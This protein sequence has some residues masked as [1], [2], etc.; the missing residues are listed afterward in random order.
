M[1][2]ALLIIP[3]LI[4]LLAGLCLP[5]FRFKERKHRE[6][7]V[8]VPVLIT[9]IIVY[10]LIFNRPEGTLTLIHLTKNLS[11]SLRLDGLSCVFAALV[12]GLWPLASCYAFEYIKHE[13]GDDRFFAFYTMTYGITLGIAFSAN[14]I[15]LYLFY[16]LLT[17]ITLP[18]VMHSMDNRSVKAGIK[19][20]A[21][22]IGG[23]ACAF[24]GMMVLYFY[25]NPELT[26]T[27]GGFMTLTDSNR[28]IV[29]IAYLLTFFGF[30]VK[31]AV[32]PFHGW[33]PSAGVAPTPVTALLHAVAVVKAGVFAIMRV[34][35]F[36][37]GVSVLRGTYAQTIAMCFAAFTIV[38]GSTMALKEQ[39]LKRRLAYSTVSNLSYILFGVTLMTPAGLTGALAHMLY[40]GVMKITLFFC[41]GAIMYK[42][43]KEYY[44]EIVGFGKKMPVT[45]GAFTV[46]SMALV[47]VPLLPGFLSKTLL[48]T[49]AVSEGSLPALLG[50]AALL[51]SAILTAAYLFT[52]VVRAFFPTKDFDEKNLEHVEDP[53]WYM[54][55]PLIV[56]CIVMVLLGLFSSNLLSTLAEIAG[57]AF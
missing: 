20:L 35:W 38:F 45:F 32:F 31:A 42:T 2:K 10:G 57:G 19:Y 3:I 48:G 22:S 47:G 33:L 30:G 28:T 39:H 51:I 46:G 50:V 43:H 55:L 36:C 27:Y 14:L 8:I 11:I 13:G 53:N 26:F 25:G 34:T 1:M 21:Y 37:F 44:P 12:A 29:L 17:L 24:L 16:E 15:T 5:L 56:L 23:A 7:Y 9:T 18:I 6:I 4:P 54:K 52:P 40:H 41:A 49:A